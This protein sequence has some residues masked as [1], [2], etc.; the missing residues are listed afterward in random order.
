VLF[1]EIAEQIDE[2][3]AARLGKQPSSSPF[4][5]FEDSDVERK[6]KQVSTEP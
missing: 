2:I 6:K 4:N 1:K 3:D 5:N